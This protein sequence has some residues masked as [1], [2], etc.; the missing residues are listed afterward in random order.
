MRQLVC[1]KCDATMSTVESGPVEVDLCERCGG[2]WF[3]REEHQRLIVMAR[4]SAVD[5]GEA[6]IGKVMDA[7]REV[8]CPVCA[9]LMDKVAVSHEPDIWVERCP[10]CGGYH[11]DAGEFRAYRRLLAL[12]FLEP[13][14]VPSA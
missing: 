7:Q 2:I 12:D 9:I 13:L 5:D 1:P 10:Q 8:V 11:F 6:S 14:E 3:D 4:G